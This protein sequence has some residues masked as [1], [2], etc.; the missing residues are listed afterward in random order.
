M[1]MKNEAF[2]E[3]NSVMKKLENVQENPALN[4]TEPSNYKF[5]HGNKNSPT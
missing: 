4:I 2:L 3:E 5:K 1:V